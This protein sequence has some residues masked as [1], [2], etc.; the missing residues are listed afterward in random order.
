MALLNK[1]NILLCDNKEALLFD[2]LI[3]DY[4]GLLRVKDVAKIL[5]ISPRTVRSWI[6]R[7]F[8]PYI[9]VRGSVRIDPKALSEWVHKGVIK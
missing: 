5:T 8:M 7:R 6:Y 3:R 4:K 9:K 1:R 2:N